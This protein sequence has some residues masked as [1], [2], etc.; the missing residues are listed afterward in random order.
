MKIADSWRRRRAIIII[1]GI[2]KKNQNS[3]KYKCNYRK[4]SLL[5]RLGF[6]N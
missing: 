1:K 4:I 5:P 3:K 6:I 2:Y